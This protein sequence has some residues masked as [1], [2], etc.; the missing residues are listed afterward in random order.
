MNWPGSG[1]STRPCF[2]RS[3]PLSGARASTGSSRRSSAWRSG[4]RLPSGLPG[5]TGSPLRRTY[6]PEVSFAAFTRKVRKESGRIRESRPT[7]VNLSWGVDRVLARVLAAPDVASAQ[8]AALDEAK[9]IAAEDTRCCH[10][11]GDYGAALLPDE[12]TVLT[13]C[14]AGALA[15]STWGTAL[16]V[17]RSAVAAGKRVKVIAC[18][19]RPLLQGPGLPHGNSHATGS[20]SRS[21][22]IPPPRTSCAPGRSMP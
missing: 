9:A 17:V 2:P 8:K 19:T 3:T 12:C 14:N 13:H 10:A 15:C 22:P 11:I 4:A 1:T 7:A 5:D 18:E 16:G 6:V 20:M 21:S